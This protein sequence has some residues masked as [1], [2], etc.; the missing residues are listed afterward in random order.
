MIEL[1]AEMPCRQLL[2]KEGRGEEKEE[3]REERIGTLTEK[4][5]AQEVVFVSAAV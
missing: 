1:T 5:E 3:E 4:E 2:V